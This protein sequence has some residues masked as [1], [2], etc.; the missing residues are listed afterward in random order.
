MKHYTEYSV[1][2]Y[3]EV[4]EEQKTEII[5]E[6]PKVS[7]PEIETISLI[8]RTFQVVK[9]FLILILVLAV[10]CGCSYKIMQFL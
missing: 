9:G 1:D 8:R 3:Q 4:Q 2:L 5:E 6:L 10:L 7:R